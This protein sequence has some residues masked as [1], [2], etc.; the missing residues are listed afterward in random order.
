MFT[1]RARRAVLYCLAA[2]IC[3]RPAPAFAQATGSITGLITDQS[4]AVMPGVTVEATNAATG[5]VRNSDP[6][7][8][9]LFCDGHAATVSTR[10]AYKAIRFR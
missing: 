1:T 3:L 6:A 5:Q 7:L 9:M 10:E 8:N 4:G 2:L